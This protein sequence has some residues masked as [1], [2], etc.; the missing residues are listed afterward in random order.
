[1]ATD[2]GK[3][4]IILLQHPTSATLTLFCKINFPHASGPHKFTSAIIQFIQNAFGTSHRHSFFLTSLLALPSAPHVLFVCFMSLSL[5][6]TTKHHT[7]THPH[8][9]AIDLPTDNFI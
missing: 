8:A 3:L 6:N 4:Q 1:M 9:N 2:A 5:F 7:V